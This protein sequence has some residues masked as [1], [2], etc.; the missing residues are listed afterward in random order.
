MRL[1][2]LVITLTKYRIN[3]FGRKNTPSGNLT[4]ILSFLGELFGT[5]RP[6][7][8]EKALDKILTM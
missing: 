6:K 5:T 3:S 2:N 8:I 4:K 7:N 1:H